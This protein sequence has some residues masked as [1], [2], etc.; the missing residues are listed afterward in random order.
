LQSEIH[1]HLNFALDV[2]DKV[3]KLV[4]VALGGIWTY[5]NYRKSRT[6]EQKLDLNIVGTVFTH[7][8]LYGDVRLTVKNIG[9]TEHIVDHDGTTCELSIIREDLSE[10]SVRF[11]EVFTDDDR[12][13]PG[14]S[15]IDT[16]YWSVP[17]SVDSILWVK[18]TLVVVSGGV[19][20]IST[21]MVRTG[22]SL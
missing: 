13:E 5:W 6:Y 17:S 16:I 12:L 15:M 21:D 14:E 2:A 9:K 7:G 22:V 1:P 10:E 20:W 8:D 4:A 19:Q 11:F 18:L 3:I